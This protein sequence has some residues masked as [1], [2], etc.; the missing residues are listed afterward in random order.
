M[1]FARSAFSLCLANSR[2]PAEPTAGGRQREHDHSTLF[3]KRASAQTRET[4]TSSRASHTV[5]EPNSQPS[6]LLRSCQKHEGARAVGLASDDARWHS[7]ICPA[8][9]RRECP[10]TLKHALQ[11]ATSTAT[12]SVPCAKRHR[13]KIS[14]LSGA[15]PARLSR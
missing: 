11:A 10:C 12:E 15:G 4:S 5:F 7:G 3:D 6:I 1:R 2:N 13:S 14:E 8:G 9:S